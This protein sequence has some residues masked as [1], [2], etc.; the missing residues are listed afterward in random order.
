[1]K[2]N[3]ISLFSV[4]VAIII[5]IYVYFPCSVYAMDIVASAHSTTSKDMTPFYWT[6]GIVGGLIAITLTYV[7]WRKYKGDKKKS[8]NNDPNS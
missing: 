1:M 5:G 2:R 8:A 6:V 3:K 7:G 4:L